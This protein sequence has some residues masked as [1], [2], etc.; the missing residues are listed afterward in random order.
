V[1]QN[2]NVMN[3]VRSGA[4]S[5]DLK[6]VWDEREELIV[7]FGVGKAEE[8]EDENRGEG[9][10]RAARAT[11]APGGTEHSASREIVKVGEVGRRERMA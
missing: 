2:N 11:S 7:L 8:D 5:L 6:D 4:A 9:E 10:E 3:K 1:P